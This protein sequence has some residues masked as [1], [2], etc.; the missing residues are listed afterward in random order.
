VRGALRTIASITLDEKEREGLS[1]EQI[2]ERLRNK[3]L[4]ALKADSAAGAQDGPRPSLG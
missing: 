3:R 2:A 1:G 4:A